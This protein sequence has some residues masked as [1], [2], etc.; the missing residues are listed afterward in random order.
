ML[1]TVT[2]SVLLNTFS[3]VFTPA[4]RPCA[5]LYSHRQDLFRSHVETSLGDNQRFDNSQRP[6][7]ILFDISYDEKLVVCN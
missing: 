1:R 3:L 7:F 2:P 4:F 5:I 6:K